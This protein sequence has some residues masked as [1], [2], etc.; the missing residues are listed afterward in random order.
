MVF[1]LHRRGGAFPTIRFDTTL[2]A[3]EPFLDDHRPGSDPLFGTT[4]GIELMRQAVEEAVSAVDLEISDIELLAPIIVPDGTMQAQI[5]VQAVPPGHRVS[6]GTIGP[7]DRLQIHCQARFFPGARM[8]SHVT[9]PAGEHAFV[10]HDEVYAC[11]FHGPAFQVVQHAF[12]ADGDVWSALAS[13]L[14]PL[15]RGQDQ[16]APSE[17]Q[18]IELCLQTAGLLDVA[19]DAKMMIPKQIE[20]ITRGRAKAGPGTLS[21]AHRRSNPD[22]TSSRFDCDLF[23]ASGDLV[24]RVSGYETQPLPFPSDNNAVQRLAESLRL[25][26]KPSA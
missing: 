2:D 19:T 8:E 23:D 18:L 9:L 12:V 15:W 21:R 14:P 17:A 10:G 11:Y 16:A 1:E 5:S 3:S 6:V 13:D 25:T 4:M 7:D 24:L 26:R 20:S 22:A